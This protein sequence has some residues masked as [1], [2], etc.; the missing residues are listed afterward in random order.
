[1]VKKTGKRKAWNS[2]TIALI[3][4]AVLVVAAAVV[5]VILLTGP[6]DPTKG[7]TVF[8]QGISIGGI[9]VSGMTGDEARPLL[10]EEAERE[11]DALTV[12]YQVEGQEFT[13]SREQLGTTADVDS[14]IAEALTYIPESSDE[15]KDFSIPKTA[16]RETVLAALEELGVNYNTEPKNAEIQVQEQEDEDS[17]T[18]SGTLVFT[19]SI[20]GNV[21]NDETLADQVCAAVENDDTETVLQAELVE[22]EPE[23]TREQ[24]EENCQLRASYTTSF[25]DSS[26]GRR[27]NI[28]KMSTVVNGVVLQPGETWSINDAA[29]DRTTE[30]GWA[31]AAGIRNGAYVDEPGGGICQVSSTLYIALIKAEIEITDRTHHS[32]PLTYV[33]VG[34][35]ATISTGGPDFKYTNNQE[36]PI[37]V[38]VNCDAEDDRTV[39]VEVYGPPMDYT[40]RFESVTIENSE[41]DDPAETVYS[42]SM[43]PGDSEWTKPRKNRIVAEIYKIKEDLDGNEISRE[44]YSTET[45]RAFT[46]EITMGPTATPEPTDEPTPTPTET[47]VPTETPTPAETQAPEQTPT[48]AATEQ[49][50]TSQEP[51]N[52]AAE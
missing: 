36:Y 42:E 27:F 6:S 34:L 21:V 47:L 23:I 1:M 38:L 29:G 28:W 39:T 52:E 4:L 31:D 35:D 33:P 24:L 2:K 44:L 40:V 37:V 43:E 9:D 12:A 14:V 30:N 20:K 17:L 7:G 50:Q 19:D 48:P 18:C 10:L 41:P 13:L 5:A 32:W 3:V 49:P 16:D 51:E 26:S 45:Y 22:V 8:A 25:E 11:L 15:T 46:G